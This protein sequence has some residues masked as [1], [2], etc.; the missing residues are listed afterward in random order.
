[1]TQWVHFSWF[2]GRK[3]L[4]VH[5]EDAALLGVGVVDVVAQVVGTDGA[6]T[7]V[8]FGGR[9]VRAKSN[10]LHPC[11]AP[12]VTLGQL[13]E[14]VA[15]RSPLRTRVRSIQWHHERNEPVFLLEGKKSRYFAN[16]LSAV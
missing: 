1:M 12:K 11:S 13:V 9:R 5:V 10:L 16:E 7:T 15:P 3:T 14:T 8:D 6:W 4:D 2:P